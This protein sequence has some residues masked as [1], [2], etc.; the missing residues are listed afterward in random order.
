MP[1][2][3]STRMGIR[4]EDAVWL[5]GQDWKKS[6]YKGQCAALMSKWANIRTKSKRRGHK[7]TQPLQQI[8]E[9]K[10]SPLRPCRHCGPAIGTFDCQPEK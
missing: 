7:A 2:R 4:P 8:D 10:E 1:S 3:R 9:S 5:P 6:H